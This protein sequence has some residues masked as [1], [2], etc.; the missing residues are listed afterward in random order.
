MEHILCVLILITRIGDI[1]STRL[2]T[3]TLQLEA[4]PLARRLGWRFICL[5]VLACL[6]PYVSPQSGA[7]AF[8]LFAVV[9]FS[10]F[11]KVWG[12]RA[13]GEARTAQIQLE[14]ARASSLSR[15]L[16]PCYVALAFLGMPGLMLM[17]VSDGWNSWTFWFAAGLPLASA[18]FA[19]HFTLFY[20]RLFRRARQDATTPV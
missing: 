2:M 15:A 20:V 5:T 9:C 16:W 19:F 18:S 17:L 4:N 13:L 1:V 10:N 3:P 6:I 14:A 7:M 11:T 8:V 12:A